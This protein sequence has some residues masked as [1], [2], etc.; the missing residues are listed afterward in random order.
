MA[1]NEDFPMD[2]TQDDIR[3]LAELKTANF[4]ALARNTAQN[5]AWAEEIKAGD[6]SSFRQYEVLAGPIPE[7][8]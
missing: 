4:H 1:V 3:Q 8:G 5:K 2:W 7:L 6:K